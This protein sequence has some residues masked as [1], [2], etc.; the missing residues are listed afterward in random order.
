MFLINVLVG[1]VYCPSVDLP[2]IL[3]CETGL[4][5]FSVLPRAVKLEGM[6]YAGYVSQFENTEY[7]MAHPFAD[8]FI[9]NVCSFQ[10]ERSSKFS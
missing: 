7:K 10:K 3:R 4:F 2:E 8:I 6:I 1:C 9:G 5:I